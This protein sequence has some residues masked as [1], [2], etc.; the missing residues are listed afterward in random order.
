MAEKLDTTPDAEKAAALAAA[1]VTPETFDF[2]NAVMDRSYPEIDVP[3]YLDERKIQR[4]LAIDAERKELENRI[5]RTAN[6][7][8][9]H[10]NLLEK[11]SDEYDEI[12]DSLK[13]QRYIVKIK[14]ISPEETIALETE[15]LEKFPV[16]YEE[17]THPAT[18]AVIKTEVESSERGELFAMLLRRAHIVSVTAPNGAVDS[19]FDDIE[20]VKYTWTHLPYVARAKVDQAINESTIAVDFY[21]SL[22]DEVF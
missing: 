18:G 4:M 13:G 12:V 9:E 20:K 3:V 16:E 7:G 21:R 15:S 2:A 14:G 5:A 17:V 1:A 22:V 8:V 19:D 10:A 6:P 11:L